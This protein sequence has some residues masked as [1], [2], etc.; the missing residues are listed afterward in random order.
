MNLS[1]LTN[2][3]LITLNGN[4]ETKEEI[5]DYLIDRLYADGKI[6][7]KESFKKAVMYRESLTPTGIDQGLAI[8]HGKDESVKEAAFAVMTLQNPVSAWESVVEGNEVKYV[9]LL[10]IPAVD[11]EGTQMKLLAEMMQ[12][13]SNETYTKAL[14]TA[15]TTKEFLERLDDDANKN[16]TQVHDQSIVAVTACAAGIAH[17]YMAA[18]ALIK[19]G[20]EMGVSVYVE[21]QGANGIEDRHTSEL[22]KNAD[23]AIFAVDV[24]V[25]EEERFAHLPTV[26]TKV[27]APLKDA[28]G[29]IEK[30]LE[31]AKQS[32]KGE[33]VEQEEEAPETFVATVK[34]SVLT[35]ISHVVPL[36]VA[37]GMIS[38]LCIIFARL[39]GFTELLNTEGTW[40][41]LIK[42][43]G[44]GLLSTLMV[45]VLS[46]YM[47]CSI[48]EKPAFASGFAAGLCANMVNG[49][50][51]LGMLGGII[52]GY[53]TRY[54]KKYIPAKGTFAGFVSFVVYPV[55]TTLIVGVVLLV[56]LG[57]PIAALNTALIDVLTSMSGGNAALLGALI[58]IMV[59]FD[60]GGPINKAAYAFCVAAMAEGVLMPY[61]AFASIKMVSAFSC[62]IATKLKKELFTEEEQEIGNST[63]LLGLAGITEGAIP[64]MMSDPIRVIISFCTG[65]AICGAIV[66]MFNIGLDVPG[67]GIFSLFVLKA[68]SLPLAMAV[69]FGAAVIGAIV[70]SVLLIVLRQQKL[71][72]SK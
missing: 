38:A 27:S 60:L 12:K 9:F 55:L 29:I 67:A 37:G 30:A 7:S 11:E 51:L 6:T 52:A 42:N 36:I 72:K 39:F 47:A 25:K 14:Y 69:W 46:A 49:G 19:A 35:G 70:S 48:A 56:I 58:G 28:K 45:P 16:T 54:V 63:W 21:K 57:K 65:S 15:K 53:A 64:F 24:A 20:E 13:M 5:I 23:A 41:Y 3:N 33:Y 71:A 68:D 2:E 43:M 10:A 59:S 66:A 34:S 17:T 8:P 26:K 44:G 22:L 4:L 40:L 18:E 1:H 62:T 61:C 32:E 50:F 31:K